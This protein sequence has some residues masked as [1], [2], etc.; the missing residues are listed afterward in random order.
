MLPYKQCSYV[1]LNPNMK[2]E[3]FLHCHIHIYKVFGD[4]PAR[5][6]CDNLK[7]NV[8]NSKSHDYQQNCPYVRNIYGIEVSDTT[9][10]R[11]TNK[12][13]PIQQYLLESLYTAAIYGHKGILRMWT[14]ENKIAKF[15]LSQRVYTEFWTVSSKLLNSSVFNRS[16]KINLISKQTLYWRHYGRL[17]FC[18]CP[19]GIIRGGRCSSYHLCSINN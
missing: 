9:I 13:L 16:L 17:L 12:I 3:N 18:I 14:A 19:L 5:T 1:E 6:F 15:T 8:I 10:S 4:L 7:T 11:I 2:K